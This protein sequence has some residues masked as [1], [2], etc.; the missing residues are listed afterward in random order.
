MINSIKHKEYSSA[1]QVNTV[2]ELTEGNV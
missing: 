1:L 2:L